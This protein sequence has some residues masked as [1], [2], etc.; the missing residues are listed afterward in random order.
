MSK[1]LDGIKKLSGQELAKSRKIVLDSI[2]ESARPEEKPALSR[3]GRQLDGLTPSKKKQARRAVNIKP[4]ET[5]KVK[6]LLAE[7][8]LG[9]NQGDNFTGQ[10]E[11][12][13]DELDRAKREEQARIK[14]LVQEKR[15][16]RKDEKKAVKN[17]AKTEKQE[18]KDLTR[19]AKEQT[20]QRQI[21]AEKEVQEK[22]DKIKQAAQEFK[23]AKK[24]QEKKIVE[25]KKAAKQEAQ[26]EIYKKKEVEKQRIKIEKQKAKEEKARLKELKREARRKAKQRRRKKQRKAIKKTMAILKKRC[27]NAWQF[28]FSWTG[29]KAVAKFLAW[30][31]IWVVVLAIFLYFVLAVLLLRFNSDEKMNKAIVNNLPVPA[32]VTK[33]GFINYQGYLEIKQS[34]PLNYDDTKLKIEIRHKAIVEIILQRLVDKYEINLKDKVIYEIYKEI[35]DSLVLDQ[36]FNKVAF[37]RINN[38]KQFLDKGGDFLDLGERYGDNYGQED[39]IELSKIQIN[40]VDDIMIT[41]NGYY[42]IENNNFIFIKAITLT[43]YLANMQS[44][45]KVWILVD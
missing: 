25:E 21:Q 3:P 31:I 23:Q 33:L 4:E 12:D 37:L 41:A 30:L 28:I 36:E 2:G 26:A 5:Q 15:Q 45:L 16:A 38:I 24:E 27:R 35:N 17:K 10:A 42:I 13:Q 39:M 32:I 9:K 1:R 43:D 22:K 19:Q 34:L 14:T 8:E 40:K 44:K 11:L 7:E 29:A 18:Q 20:R 6:E